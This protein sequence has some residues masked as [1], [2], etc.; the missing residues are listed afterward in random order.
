MRVLVEQ[1]Y[2]T[3][4]VCLMPLSRAKQAAMVRKN[5]MCHA[6]MIMGQLTWW[7]SRR[8]RAV[9]LRVCEARALVAQRHA[10]LALIIAL[11]C[12][13][14]EFVMLPRQDV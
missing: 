5:V 11:A 14:T 7:D 13:T 12:T 4:T 6:K 8:Q 10:M 9:S 1:K 3:Q 2:A